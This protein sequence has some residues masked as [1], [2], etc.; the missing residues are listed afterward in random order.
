MEDSALAQQL[1]RRA[2]IVC[3][4]YA[5]VRGGESLSDDCEHSLANKDL[6]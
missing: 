1:V 2:T 5:I 6:E 4:P 3:Y